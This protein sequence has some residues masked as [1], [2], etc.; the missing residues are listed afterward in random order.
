MRT[1]ASN[2]TIWEIEF[3]EI[4]YILLIQ[5]VFSLIL[6]CQNMTLQSNYIVSERDTPIQEYRVE[7][8]H[9]DPRISCRKV[10]LRSKNTVS[11]HDTPIQLYSIERDTPI[12]LYY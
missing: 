6:S 3:F 1:H 9:F 12:Q 11:K 8:W 4:E 10:T 7:M 2:Q 5:Y